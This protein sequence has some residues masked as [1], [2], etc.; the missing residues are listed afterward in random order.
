MPF[1]L[2]H[3]VLASPIAKITRYKLPIGAL[4]IGCMTP[5]LVRLFTDENVTI[6]HEWAGLIIPDLLLGLI[7]CVLWY[8]LYRPVLYYWLSLQDDLNLATFSRF[9]SFCIACI[10]GVIIGCATHIIWD[11]LTHDDFR[12]FAFQGLLSQDILF[13]GRTYPIHRFLQLT[14]S[15]VS[16]PILGWMCYRYMIEYRIQKQRTS[17]RSLSL[18]IFLSFAVGGFF[19]FSYWQQLDTQL[20]HT[21]TYAVTGKAIN[22]FSRGFLICFSLSCLIFILAKW[23][24]AF[25][26]QKQN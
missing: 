13:L 10:L 20:W 3:A 19:L 23:F 21:D 2:S 12:T 9:C 6:S 5:D 8:V 18:T 14:T 1:T 4:A 22:Y 26:A 11:G 24:K 7:F 15:V 17:Y 25:S 16:L